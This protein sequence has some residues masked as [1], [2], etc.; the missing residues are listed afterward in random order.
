M[1]QLKSLVYHEY[2]YQNLTFEQRKQGTLIHVY[3]SG[4]ESI[5]NNLIIKCTFGNVSDIINEVF[6]K[7][8]ILDSPFEN[9]FNTVLSCLYEDI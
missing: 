4:T 3:M 1:Y 8:K 9:V 2:Q 7:K 6:R 5:L